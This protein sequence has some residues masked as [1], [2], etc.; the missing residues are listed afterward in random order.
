MSH[1][2]NPPGHL[3]CRLC[4]Q[5]DFPAMGEVAPGEPQAQR[6]ACD[7]NVG[8][9]SDVFSFFVHILWFIS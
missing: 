5:D 8:D 9:F 1:V 7:A 2:R 3:C 4:A 6:V